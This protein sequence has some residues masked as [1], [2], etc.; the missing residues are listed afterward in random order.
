MSLTPSP[1][2][3]RRLRTD[4]QALRTIAVTLV[5]LFHLW[6][7]RISGGFVGVDVFFVISGFLICSIILKDLQE[8]KFS[9]ASFYARRVRRIFPALLLVMMSS[10][11]FGWFA[12]LPDEFEQFG[13]HFL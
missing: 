4:I 10:Y 7:N 13:K 1:F 2:I 6:P 12:L 5:V 11:I 3:T 9:S 8:N